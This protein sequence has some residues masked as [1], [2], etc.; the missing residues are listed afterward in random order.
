[1][2]QQSAL[3]I[4]NRPIRTMHRQLFSSILAKLFFFCV[5]VPDKSVVWDCF[6]CAT[7]K[8]ATNVI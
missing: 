8:T 1:M 4:T 3:L 6:I 5:K 7:I 2:A